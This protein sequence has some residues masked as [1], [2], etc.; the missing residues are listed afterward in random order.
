MFLKSD[1]KGAPIDYTFERGYEAGSAIRCRLGDN[2]LIWGLELAIME[3]HGGE[4]ENGLQK[5][6]KKF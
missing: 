3:M 4:Q 6:E 5:S 1:L 2:T